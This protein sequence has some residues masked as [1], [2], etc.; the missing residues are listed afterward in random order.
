MSENNWEKESKL[1]TETDFRL[2]V[3]AEVDGSSDSTRRI[4]VVGFSQVDSVASKDFPCFKDF[5]YSS[6]SCST[7][8]TQWRKCRGGSRSRPGIRIG[9]VVIAREK[10]GANGIGD[11]G[12]LCTVAEKIIKFFIGK[13]SLSKLVDVCTVD[14]VFKN[15]EF[16]SETDGA[17]GYFM[18]SFEMG[19]ES[20]L[21]SVSETKSWLQDILTL[22]PRCYINAHRW[23]SLSKLNSTELT[24]FRSTRWWNAQIKLSSWLW[25]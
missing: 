14:V 2:G 9:W 24:F 4:K 17:D 23:A 1:K 10:A 25:P 20:R 18:F 5:W 15:V 16:I 12:G 6:Y 13:M 21:T 7:R 22:C 3:F 11:R 8:S 19:D